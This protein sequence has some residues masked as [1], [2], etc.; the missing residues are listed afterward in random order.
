MF[1][2]WKSSCFCAH[3][4][5]LH[6]E[7]VAI[8]HP[9]CLEP[10][11]G[12][13][14]AVLAVLPAPVSLCPGPPSV[15]RRGTYQFARDD[16]FILH[17]CSSARKQRDLASIS[18]GAKIA[19]AVALSSGSERTRAGFESG[20]PGC[21]GPTGRFSGFVMTLP[22][23]GGRADS[24]GGGPEPKRPKQVAQ[25]RK[26]CEA[27]PRLTEPHPAADDRIEHPGRKGH[28]TS[29][30]DLDLNDFAGGASLAVRAD[31]TLSA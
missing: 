7:G 8:A 15:T 6:V 24:G 26:R 19:I 27:G 29:G 1:A 2:S 9:R 17:P 12:Q 30:V 10:P 13:R 11:L 25:V 21:L 14:L 22:P 28:D 31:N 20:K 5:V 4:E 3:V 16:A 18:S 23:V